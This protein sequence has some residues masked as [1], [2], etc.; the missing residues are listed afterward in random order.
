MNI[1]SRLLS[2]FSSTEQVKPMRYVELFNKLAEKNQAAFVPFVTLGDPNIELSLKIIDA[3]VVGGADALEL[4]IPFSDPLA[5]GPTIQNANLRAFKAGITPD[6][7]FEM[8]TIIRQKYPQIPI[9]LLMYANLV[10]SNG[11]EQFFA[12]CQKVG[13]DSVL[14]ADVPIEESSIFHEIA[15]K[16]KIDSIYICP[17]NADEI[18]IEKIA[19]QGSGYTYLVSRGGVT[20]TESKADMPIGHVLELLKKHNAAPAILGFGISNPEQVK[21]AIEHGAAG[22]IVGSALVKMIE[23]GLGNEAELLSNIEEYVKTLKAAT[24]LEAKI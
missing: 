1:F 16:F 22:A 14:I 13:V 8:L 2:I 4:G 12:K 15:Q 23:A 5:D 7:C 6:K 10:F 24:Q 20:G 17:P 21:S 9:G 11:A 19:A 18:L 3:L